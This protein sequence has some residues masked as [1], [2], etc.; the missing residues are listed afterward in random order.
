MS[1]ATILIFYPIL[2]IYSPSSDFSRLSLEISVFS[3]KKQKK[4]AKMAGTS[5]TA[6]FG[7][8]EGDFPQIGVPNAH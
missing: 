3:R 4:M 6:T 8:R 2:S 5:E 1:H 7:V